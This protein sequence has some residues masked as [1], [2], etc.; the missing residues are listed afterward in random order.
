MQV[1][2]YSCGCCDGEDPCPHGY[3]YNVLDVDDSFIEQSTIFTSDEDND[4]ID[5]CVINMENPIKLTKTQKKN[6]KR[7]AKRKRIH[8]IQENNDDVPPEKNA[9]KSY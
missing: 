5:V 4:G 2:L 6:L 8:G 7:W 3:G 9:T 1:E